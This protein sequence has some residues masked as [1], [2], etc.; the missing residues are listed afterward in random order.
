M[1]TELKHSKCNTDAEKLTEFQR[2]IDAQPLNYTRLYQD[3]T[4]ENL[5]Y[6]LNSG[7]IA[8]RVIARIVIKH[9]DNSLAYLLET[10]A[11]MQT[12]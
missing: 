4:P 8:I 11:S 6:F 12:V 7:S 9:R 10:K 3:F 2:L 1:K 5:N